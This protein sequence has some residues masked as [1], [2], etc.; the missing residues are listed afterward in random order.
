MRWWSSS[1]ACSDARSST[2][3]QPLAPLESTREL[4]IPRGVEGAR[5]PATPRAR[6]GLAELR[7]LELPRVSAK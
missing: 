7:Y 5:G 6:R 2:E 1:P 3:R 4:W